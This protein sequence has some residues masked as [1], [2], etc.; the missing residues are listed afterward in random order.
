MLFIYL[1]QLWFI[2]GVNGDGLNLKFEFFGGILVN[3]QNFNIEIL[4]LK[5][6]F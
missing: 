1:D 2:F 6:V 5:M 4:A 3:R